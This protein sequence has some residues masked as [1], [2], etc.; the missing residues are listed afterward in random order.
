M[1]PT[2]AKELYTIDANGELTLNFHP[3]QWSVWESTARIVAMIAGSQ[4]GKTSFGTWWLYREIQQHGGGDYIAATATFDLFKLKLLPEIREVFEHVLKIGRYWSGDKILELR[5]PATGKFEATRADDRM[6]GRVIL[7]AASSTGGLESATAKAAWLDEAG[8][9]TF[10]L[11]AWDAVRRRLTLHRGRVLITTTPYNLGW[12]KQQIV[13]KDGQNG[14]EV[15]R[16]ESTANPRFS[17]EEFEDLRASM[18]KWKFD[19]FMRGLF[20]RPPGMI[21]GD[22]IDA[23]REDGGHKVKPFDLPTEWPRYV[24]VDPGAVNTAMVWLAH[25]TERNIFYLYR[26]SLEGGKST[27]QHAQGAQALADSHHENVIMYA[28]GQKSEVQ[29]RLDWQE[30][31]IY[32]VTEPSI[33]DV[34]GGI[35]RVIELLKQHRLYIFDTCEKTLDQIGRYARV[36]D[37]MGETTE[38]IKDKESFHLLDALRYDVIAAADTPAWE[39]FVI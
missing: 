28:V 13:D 10:I 30:A 3:G 36:L 7:R 12:L 19:M 25:D 38:K 35:D 16:F 6:Y 34:E 8:Q 22:Y 2:K 29:Q 5:N 9:D 17:M 23:Y 33:H 26:E 24:G 32:N 20:S 14:I 27:R 18:P 4:G 11:D 31:G 21:Y 1:I 39:S 37:S 15:I